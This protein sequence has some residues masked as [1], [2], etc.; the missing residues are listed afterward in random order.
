MAGRSYGFS[1]AG[2]EF[3]E[4]DDDLGGFSFGGD[5][6]KEVDDVPV[7][8][9]AGIATSYEWR[10]CLFGYILSLFT[11]DIFKTLGDNSLLL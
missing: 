8:C 2:Y 5:S 7:V 10:I 6:D 9:A 4:F 1:P 11:S 3:D